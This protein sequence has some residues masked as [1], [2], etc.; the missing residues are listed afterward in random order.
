MSTTLETHLQERLADY[1][2]NRLSLDELREW[3]AVHTMNVYQMGNQ[4]AEELTYEIELLLAEYAHGDWTDLQLKD[5]FSELVSPGLV[6][7]M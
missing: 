6:Q 1:L 7:E 2:A 4:A 3:V 5:Q